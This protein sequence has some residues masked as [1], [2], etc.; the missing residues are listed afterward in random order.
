M[1]LARQILL[2]TTVFGIC[3]AVH[4]A[5]VAIS[6]PLLTNL[7]AFSMSRFHRLHV[8]LLLGVAFAVMV[9]A[10][11]VQVWVWALVFIW[12]EALPDMETSLYFA[13]AT[14]TTLGYGDIVLDPG[15]RIFASFASV[16]GLLTFGI[17]TAFLMGVITRVFREDRAAARRNALYRGP[18]NTS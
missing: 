17:S 12:L 10:H 8:F 9:F 5:L 15:F 7:A 16:T 1:D 18:G 14:Y 3:A 11:T 6:I 2:G 13:M 4:V